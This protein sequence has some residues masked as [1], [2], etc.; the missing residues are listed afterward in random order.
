MT[1]RVAVAFSVVTIA[2]TLAGCVTEG[3]RPGSTAAKTIADLNRPDAAAAASALSGVVATPSNSPVTNTRIVVQVRALGTVPYDGQTLPIA[4]PDGRFLVTQTGLAPA[5]PTVLAQ[6]D[7]TPASGSGFVVYDL[8]KQPAAEIAGAARPPEGSILG[9]GADTTGFLIESPRPDG[10]RWIG[11]VSWVSGETRWLARGA[12]ICAHASLGP[13][14]MLAFSSRAP[15]TGRSTIVIQ[16]REGRRDTLSDPD[17]AWVYPFFSSDA[18]TLHAFRL[19]GVGIELI[20]A[21][22]EP[23][24]PRIGGITSRRRIAP[25][26]DLFLAYS[27]VA[28]AQTPDLTSPPQCL[29]F[30]DPRAKRMIEITLPSGLASILPEG[31]VAAARVPALARDGVFV[32]TP[33]GLVFSPD[34]SPVTNPDGSARPRP[35]AGRLFDAPHIV[36][37][38]PKNDQSP[39]LLLGPVSGSSEP[40]ISVI[41]VYPAPDSEAVKPV[42]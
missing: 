20:S 14:G 24:I 31:S 35:D 36:R 8:S 3:R 37:P 33:K 1:P 28:S 27:T 19:S 34:P 5:W 9:R 16:N 12:E 29:R 40:R 13:D 38:T 30:L 2:I 4:S 41:A 23:S 42:K 17:A 39:F 10:S 21:P 6:D 25:D 7:A 11:H 32:T 18:R 15:G 22:V 26:P